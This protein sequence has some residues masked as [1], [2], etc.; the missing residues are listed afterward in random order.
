MSRVTIVSSAV[1]VLAVFT[2]LALAGPLDPP[3]GPPTPTFRTLSEIE[4]RIPIDTLPGDAFATHLITQPGSYYL[5]GPITGQAGKSGIRVLVSDVTIDLGGFTLRGVAG[6]LDGIE[7]GTIFAPLE[8]ITVRNGIVRGWGRVGVSA[9]QA[10]NV[11][12]E[13]ITASQNGSDGIRAGASV[14]P[15]NGSVIRG[16]V[17]FGN[18]GNGISIDNGVVDACTAN[19]NVGRGINAQ[20]STVANSTATGNEGDGIG[21]SG[22]LTGS[23]AIANR[24]DGIRWSGTVIGCRSSNNLGDGIQ[25]R[26]GTVV[27]DSA[28]S[29]NGLNG[30]VLEDGARATDCIARENS[31]HGFDLLDASAVIKSS[32]IGN[33]QHGIRATGEGPYIDGNH[34]VRNGLGII[35][36]GIEATVVRNTVSG[37]SAYQLSP[38]TTA[39]AIL[40][41]GGTIAG[42]GPLDNIAN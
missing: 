20:S 41:G 32:A 3:A 36:L 15:P 21:G 25:A 30:F 13:A 37:G 35:T 28:A 19:S 39:G 9:E 29:F 23:T 7:V 38:T 40:I 5:T 27:R 8:N 16:C 6:S 33:A 10:S 12:I 31:A 22:S 24:Q 11:L 18:S 1:A 42:A 14:S 17:A 2:L 26:V 4:P 34:L